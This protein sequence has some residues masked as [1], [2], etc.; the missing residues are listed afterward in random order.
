[1]ASPAKAILFGASGQLGTDLQKTNPGFEIV[2]FRQQDAD[3]ADPAKL[4]EMVLS[5]QPSWVINAAALNRT[6]DCEIRPD[7][8]FAINAHGPGEL[9]RAAAEVDAGFVH[10]STDY[11]FDGESDRPYREEDAPRPLSVYGV[12]KLK[13]EQLVLAGHP[14]AHVLRTASL[15]GAAGSRGK[16]GGFVHVLA[17]RARRNENADVVKDIFMSPTFTE[18]LARATW[19]VIHRR[20]APGLYHAVNQGEG[21]WFDLAREI[22][23]LL[24][25]KA[26]VNPVSAADHPAKIRRPARSTL[27]SE[28]LTAAGISA[29][30]RPWQSALKACLQQMEP[31]QK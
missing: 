1:M 29:L 11:V 13:G 4:R 24:G 17:A 26:E 10:F 31:I 20:P 8:A 27:S 12:S 2:G 28:K 30:S 7:L 3:F 5:Q 6:E 25:S 15:F 18:D 14:G 19:D 22:Y 9:A 16:N 21:S 23:R